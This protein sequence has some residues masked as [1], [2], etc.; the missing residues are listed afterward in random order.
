MSGKKEV[1]KKKKKSKKKSTIYFFCKSFL[2]FSLF[3]SSFLFF[4]Q[5]IFQKKN[6]VQFGNNFVRVLAIT[7]TLMLE[8]AFKNLDFGK[9]SMVF[10]NFFFPFRLSTPDEALAPIGLTS[11]QR[12]QTTHGPATVRKPFFFQSVSETDFAGCWCWKRRT[13]VVFFRQRQ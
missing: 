9:K 1:G 6:S 2:L 7:F 8:V 4:F 12:V 13:C 5:N 11:F 10:T 3:F